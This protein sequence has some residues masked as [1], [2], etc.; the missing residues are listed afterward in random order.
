MYTRSEMDKYKTSITLIIKPGKEL[1]RK[2]HCIEISLIG[3]TMNNINKWVSSMNAEL[4]NI[5][6]INE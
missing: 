1:S 2:I 6:E 5:R 3:N 4:L